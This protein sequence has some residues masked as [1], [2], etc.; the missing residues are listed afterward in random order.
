MSD[1]AVG[2]IS[3]ILQTAFKDAYD[4]KKN[5]EETAKRKKLKEKLAAEK[6][7]RAAQR[8]ERRRQIEEGEIEP[9]DD[10]PEE[11]EDEEPAEEDEEDVQDYHNP[12]DDIPLCDEYRTTLDGRVQKVDQDIKKKTEDAKDLLSY[13][14]TQ[15]QIAKQLESE[16]EDM[17]KKQGVMVGQHIP[18]LVSKLDVDANVVNNFG[19]MSTNMIIS[20][21]LIDKNKERNLRRTG[22]LPISQEAEERKTMRMRNKKD[23]D[24][25][26]PHYLQTTGTNRER[27]SV[28]AAK[29]S[30]TLQNHHTHR[31]NVTMANT[32]KGITSSKIPKRNYGQSALD[33]ERDQTVL[34]NINHSL[35]YLRAPRND[36]GAVKK[37]LVNTSAIKNKGMGVSSSQDDST[38]SGHPSSVTS[39]VTKKSSASS[40]VAPGAL[41]V[42]EPGTIVFDS[43][44][45]GKEYCQSIS[46]RN[47]SSSSRT[48]RVIPP[49]SPHFSL[50]QLKYPSVSKGGVIAPGMCVKADLMFFPQSLA[51]YYDCL[52][53]ETEGGS[54]EVEIVAKRDPP[55]LSLPPVI[56]IGNCLVGDATRSSISCL[57]SGGRGSFKIV[58]ASH[59]PDI[60][61]DVDFND[62]MRIPPFTIYPLE[63][64]LD[65]GE[66][67]DITLE[68]M[69]LT[70]G[71]FEE[72]IYVVGDNEQAISVSLKSKGRQID[73]FISEINSLPVPVND[74]RVK[75]DLFFAPSF[76]GSDNEQ[77]IVIQNDTGIAVE[78]EW[79]WLD[80]ETDNIL[81]GGLEELIMNESKNRC[82]IDSPQHNKSNSGQQLGN[83]SKPVTASDVG[84]FV[85]TDEFQGGGS[86]DERTDDFL[87]NTGFQ[88]DGDGV[89]NHAFFDDFGI[90]P[91][92][93]VLAVNGSAPFVVSYKASK[94]G[95]TSGKAVLMLRDV[96]H[97]SVPGDKQMMYLEEMAA[98]GHGSFHRLR[99]WIEEIGVKSPLGITERAEQTA[100]EEGIRL[101]NIPTNRITIDTLCSL[102][103][104]HC[105]GADDDVQTRFRYII[106]RMLSKAHRI[107]NR[108]TIQLD[109]DDSVMLAMEGPPLTEGEVVADNV[110]RV[111][112]IEWNGSDAQMPIRYP[113][114]DID[115]P[116]E[117]P[118]LTAI[119]TGY[120]DI[121]DEKASS[122]RKLI[123]LDV[124]SC[125]CVLG[126]S[127]STILESLIKHDAIDFIQRCA[128][129]S[130]PVMAMDVTGVGIPP[131]IS[132]Y[133]PKLNVGGE[134][135]IGKPWRGT[136]TFTNPTSMICELNVDPSRLKLGSIVAPENIDISLSTDHVVIL[137]NE[138]ESVVVTLIIDIIGKFDMILPVTAKCSALQVND[139][140]I[141]VATVGPKVRFES[142]DLDFGL[143]STGC[144]IKKVTTFSNDTDIPLNY[145]LTCVVGASL[146]GFRSPTKSKLNVN[147]DT[148]SLSSM[149]S[150][151]RS[152]M[153]DISGDSFAIDNPKASY[154]FDPPR[155]TLG[156]HE[157]VQ[158]TVTC[159]GGKNPER[160]RGVVECRVSDIKH[161]CDL[162]IQY[163]SVRGEVQSPLTIVYPSVIDIGNVYINTPVTF[164]VFVR[165]VSS[166]EAK[167]KFE[168]PGGESSA[169]RMNFPENMKSGPLAGR[170]IREL[171]IEF[172]ALNSGI[173]DD[174]YGCKIFGSTAPLGF[175]IK[176]IAKGINVDFKPL[177]EGEEPPLPIAKP[178]DAQFPGGPDLIPEMYPP[179]PVDFGSAVDLYER[180]SRRFVI[181]NLSAMAAH[182]N[183]RP[184]K[185]D[186]GEN[187]DFNLANSPSR[188]MKGTLV[189]NEDGENR[190]HSEGGKKYIG[191]LLKRREDKKFLTLGLGCS[192][193]V[194][195]MNGVVEPW[196][197]CVINVL[198]RNDMPGCFDDD[199]LIDVKDHRRLP[200]PMKMNVLGCPLVIERDSFGMSRMKNTGKDVSQEDKVV[201]SLAPLMLEMGNASV[202][203]DPLLREFRVRNNGAFPATLKWKLRSVQGKVNGP[204]K[205]EVNLS[206]LG[207]KSKN[208]TKTSLLFWDDVAKDSP[209]TVDPKVT[210]IPAYG[211]K[212][213]KVK[214][215]RTTSEGEELALLSGAISFGGEES[216][217]EGLNDSTTVQSVVDPN[218]PIK[219]SPPSPSGGRRSSLTGDTASVNVANSVTSTKSN[220]KS[221]FSI[222]LHLRAKLVMPMMKI[223]S[224]MVTASAERV[225]KVPTDQGIKLSAH[226]PLLFASGSRPSEVCTQ[227]V[228][229]TNP[230]PTALL[231][232]ISID[233]PF[234]IKAITDEEASGKKVKK[235]GAVAS[236]GSVASVGTNKSAITKSVAGSLVGAT[237]QLLAHKSSRYLIAFTPRRDLRSKM[238]NNDSAG[239]S[240]G[241]PDVSESGSFTLSFSTGHQI[242]VPVT[243]VLTTPFI[244]ASSPRMYFGVCHTTQTTEGT[245]LLNAPTDVLARW[246]VTHIPGAGGSRKVSSIRVQG[247]A[248]PPVQADDP[249]VFEI[250][251]D[252]GV[253]QGPTVSP[254]A[255]M[256]CPPN[257]VNRS[258]ALAVIEQRP[259]KT[260]WA[261]QQLTMKD[262]LATRHHKSKV[263]EIDP[264]FPLPITVKF[265]PTKST[266]YSSRFRFSCEYGNTFDVLLEGQGTFEEHEHNPKTPHP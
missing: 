153:T 85:E 37:T 146:G 232:N 154:K 136:V 234:S 93:G 104:S 189:A 94:K 223:G 222:S 211:R 112:F 25:D 102:V 129:I 173:I 215:L 31:T 224:V 155:G 204:L 194:E 15:R 171:K 22:N 110:V 134:L 167:Y 169:Y 80:Y 120:L 200:L 201:D 142:P 32:A 52:Q 210:V 36:P 14:G 265:K 34:K 48:I 264:I 58:R 57:N 18:S 70:I 235:D 87:L 174:I 238:L 117:I 95:T 1:A 151:A 259:V 219:S 6:A 26:I 133:P 124:T 197:V 119:E 67:I 77:E 176:A 59:Y 192:Y 107:M 236:G 68:F 257:D 231:F 143:I 213:F 79:V 123:W 60:P 19:E 205:V 179:T 63:F 261:T 71:D 29:F 248:V 75:K 88:I 82:L 220:Q 16:E 138:T 177:D 55:V 140:A 54:Y 209:F 217:T 260:S 218:A 84:L 115:V 239:G 196:G 159:T 178:T 28:N 225:V 247:F 5:I 42:A 144:D 137:P 83:S 262:S 125:L 206:A 78:Y 100:L 90:S 43:Y 114:V 163:V 65:K 23:E 61:S 266:R 91:C 198:A 135:A 258:S 3:H 175:Q 113:L 76:V 254:S 156:P 216:L 45:V 62:C 111:E 183:I 9:D 39:S 126:D 53:V 195:P 99:S 237:I 244:S 92:R 250:T 122:I 228:T 187:F 186:V 35:N 233:G 13:L 158:T 24:D 51:D 97:Q 255:A 184:R 132:F 145:N 180:V 246:T 98:N 245:L 118:D 106:G 230:L 105:R 157:S 66:S 128:R 69:P 251:P 199:L 7:E 182:F 27:S 170:E 188:P 243:T 172:T 242:Y 190:Y 49:A 227:V 130:L 44:E 127:L 166:L 2:S 116:E 165:N 72:V 226:A 253:L 168:R 203:A 164:S 185:H 121:A 74:D 249:S 108:T 150:T 56:D 41:F 256:Y 131:V 252:N 17:L 241:C 214:L 96:T 12:V 38:V 86:P 263:K 208:K 147:S 240:G 50:Q 21:E 149:P 148:E 207:S 20:R 64:S 221:S 202:N 30:Q 40:S 193:V 141:S 152:N 103:K 73:A 139:I 161:L 10:E 162:P 109:D 11:E 160:I 81:R 229:L 101:H 33:K 191:A 47:I 8:E 4:E 46:F 212:N 181:R 89:S